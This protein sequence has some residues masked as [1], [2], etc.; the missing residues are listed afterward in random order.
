MASTV[1]IIRYDTENWY[2]GM[3][4]NTKLTKK[5]HASIK[6]PEKDSHRDRE[7]ITQT[8]FGLK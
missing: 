1:S 7:Y 4:S 3:E 5:N 2:Y 8:S 6:N